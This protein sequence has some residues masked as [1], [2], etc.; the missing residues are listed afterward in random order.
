MINK[1]KQELQKPIVK[2]GLIVTTVLLL[3]Q[4]VFLPWFE[5]R[6]N[7]SNDLQVKAGFSIERSVLEQALN[8]L[9]D[10]QKLLQTDLK[11]L[12]SS[13]A[14]SGKGNAKV[15][16]PTQVRQICEEFDV[17]VNRVSVTELESKYEGLNSYMVSVEA[18]GSVDRLFKLIEKLE[19]DQSFFVVDRMTIYSRRKQQMKVRME[20]QKHVEN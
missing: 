11:I 18:Q 4:K 17:K 20:L 7:L 19:S 10:K 16:M 13:F 14:E 5:W 1:L 15:E 12:Q 2:Y 3:I 9:T 8:S 6:Q